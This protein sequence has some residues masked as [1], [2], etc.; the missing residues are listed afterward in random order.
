[1][2]GINHKTNAE[3]D[4][5]TKHM[6]LTEPLVKQEKWFLCRYMQNLRGKKC[7]QECVWKS[8]FKICF[9]NNT[10]AIREDMM[11][12]QTDDIG[13]ACICLLAEDTDDACICLSADILMMLVSVYQQTEDTDDAC[14]CLSADR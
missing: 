9:W 4:A 6:L 5:N 1:V 8:E 11:Y 14:I 12:Q 3:K 10:A 7:T 2:Q 13:V